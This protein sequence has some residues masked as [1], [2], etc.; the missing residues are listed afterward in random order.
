MTHMRV[1]KEVV[2]E[3]FS[4]DHVRTSSSRHLL[5]MANN[6]FGFLRKHLGNVGIFGIT[7]AVLEKITE[8]GFVCPCDESYNIAI[9]SLYAAVPAICCVI[10]TL[11]Y[12]DLS[13]QTDRV[14][15]DIPMINF[16]NDYTPPSLHMEDGA[17][18]KICTCKKVKYSILTAAIWICLFFLDGRYMACALSTWEGVYTKNESL[19]ILKW[20]KP[21][22]NETSV[23]DSQQ[24][25]LRCMCI[26]QVSSELYTTKSFVFIK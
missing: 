16:T 18:Q 7:L 5:T 11:C 6:I 10:Y 1:Y 8:D 22:G 20:C 21:T 4:K 25:T 2:T 26:S 24:K 13:P 12:M 14:T 15:Q 19:G 17:T 3:D 23:L 9:C